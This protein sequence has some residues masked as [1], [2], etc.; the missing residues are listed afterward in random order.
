M[1]PQ[2]TELISEDCFIVLTTGLVSQ[3]MPQRDQSVTDI[4]KK[5]GQN[6]LK[7]KRFDSLEITKSTYFVFPVTVLTTVRKMFGGLISSFSIFD[8]VANGNLYERH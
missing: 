7:L 8:S 6:L 3:I 2:V 1:S 4:A 5:G